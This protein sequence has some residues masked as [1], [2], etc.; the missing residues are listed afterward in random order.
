MLTKVKAD[1]VTLGNGRKLEEKLANF[2]DV[3]DYGASPS[4]TAT[5][6]TT[7]INNAIQN[8]AAGYIIVPAGVSFTEN[9]I[10]F[11]SNVTLL[12][13]DTVGRITFLSAATGNSPVSR[14]GIAVK[15]QGTAG[16]LLRAVDLGVASE[17]MLQ[18]TSL[19]ADVIAATHTKF[20]ELDEITAPANPAANK[21]RL[22]TRDNGSG[23]TQLVVQFPTGVVQVLA[24]EP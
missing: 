1:F 7:A 18:V 16:V 15:Q 4:G 3:L 10:V 14:S 11:T 9:S 5:A 23:K 17:P 24:T 21:S 19:S 13:L 6:N 22:Y 12:V 20:V 2:V 8:S